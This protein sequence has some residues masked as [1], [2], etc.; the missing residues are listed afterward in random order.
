VSADPLKVYRAKRNFKITSE[1]SGGEVAPGR[2]LVVQHHFATRDHYDLRLEI[3]GVL[4]S[5]AVTR[6]PSANPRDKRLA[7]RT[8]DHPLSYG[9]FEGEIPKGQYGGG[10]V[11]LWEYATYSPLNGDPAAALAKG[12]LKFEGHG[13]RM[14]GGWVLVRMKSK[15][16]HENWLLIKERDRFAEDDDSLTARFPGSVKAKAPKSRRKPDP[17]PAFQPPQLCESADAPP[18]GPDWVY[19]IKYDGYR[20]ELAVGGEAAKLYTRSGL[21][22]T[23][24]LPGLAA[25]AARLKCRSALI[26]GE[27]V[28]FDAKGVSDFPGLVAALERRQ[29]GAVAY[30]A[31][32]L[33]AL[34]GKDLRKRPLEA[35]KAA[36]KTLIGEG[37]QSIRYAEH[38]E[39]DGRAVFEGAVAAG[40]EGVI[41]KDRK[42]PYSGKRSHAFVKIKGY[43]RT[44]VL[45]VAY[46]PSERMSTFA[47]LHAAVEEDGEWRYVGGIGT[48]FSDAQRT[49]LH[50]RFAARASKR[51]PERLKAEVPAGLMF[52][53]RPARAEV[54]FGGWTGTGHL[55]QA[56]F[57][58]L[59][60]DLPMS[61]APK[62]AAAKKPPAITHADRVVYPDCGVTKGQIAE[63]YAA[64]AERLAPH[65]EGRPLSLVRAPD[66]IAETF[67]QRHPL[68]GMTAGVAPVE[69][70]DETY[71]TL[72]GATGLATAAQFGA[73]ELHGWMSLIGALDSPDRMVFD[74]D[75]DEGLPFADVVRAAQDIAKGLAELGLQSWPM[76]S[77]GKGVHVVLP[78]DGTAD[79]AETEAF[80]KGFAQALAA[81]DPSR[82]VANMSKER[83]KGRIFVDWLRN[84]KSSTAVMPWSL[85]AR[86]GAHV[87]TP[88]SWD[89]LAKAKSA[90]AFDIRSAQKRKDPWNK[91]FSTRQKPPK[92]APDGVGGA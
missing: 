82:F 88:L 75:P 45:I 11:I 80:A 81:H 35:R 83:R 24:K 58:A 61:P 47:S 37:L 27:A 32:D 73:I 50:E 16:K 25:E 69:I 33:L 9:A 42:A 12:E 51:R 15:E 49:T 48:G 90:A 10:Q 8:E 72:D 14:R 23:A 39:G 85:R 57:L 29:T 66:T 54:R 22:W 65:I 55:R 74:L 68:K 52:V 84:K 71:M 89:E 63:Y 36:L 44:D 1:P 6:G 4:A 56:R 53:E 5:W 17:P 70:G 41:A 2:R 59:R 3:D 92:F 28:V 40:A 19:E 13:E 62:R 21:D 67:F 46:K 87:A 60:E 77:G 91:F 76:L 30:L 20:L 38:V 31:F 7:V 43:P 64:V 26:D 18:E 79:Y 78:L 86:P 34:D